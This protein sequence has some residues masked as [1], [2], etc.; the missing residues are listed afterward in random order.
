[1]KVMQRAQKTKLKTNSDSNEI[2]PLAASKRIV[3]LL[4]QTRLN[5]ADN[6]KKQMM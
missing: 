1:M 2:A 3:L 4:K 5:I 6:K